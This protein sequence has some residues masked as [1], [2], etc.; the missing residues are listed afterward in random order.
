VR[1]G[2]ASQRL[3]DPGAGAGFV[4]AARG[5]VAQDEGNVKDIVLLQGKCTEVNL[6]WDNCDWYVSAVY[7]GA[8]YEAQGPVLATVV[9]DVLAQVMA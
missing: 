5:W 9:K 4:V 3:L 8:L 2:S 6:L 7:K 1:G